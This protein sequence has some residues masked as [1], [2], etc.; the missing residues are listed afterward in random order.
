MTDRIEKK[1]VLRAPRA[2]VWRAIS[3]QGEFAAWFGVEFPQGTFRP[4]D[5]VSG[6]IT[7][8]RYE[9]L[10]IDIDVVEV[11]PEQRLSYRWHPNAI[12]ERGGYSKEPKTLVTFTL[13]ERKEGTLLTIV[14]S[15][16][17]KIPL[18]RRE[19]AFKANDGGWTGQLKSIE[20]YVT[21]T[22]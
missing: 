2:R 13:E 6:K 10:T 21:E 3:D 20:R 15:G 22:R 18:K 14:E 4:G 11:V 16:F 8:R 1:I 9:H 5:T 12:D 19:E 17:D 7:H